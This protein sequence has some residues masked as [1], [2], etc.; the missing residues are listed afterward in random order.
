MSSMRTG[1]RSVP[2]ER[3]SGPCVLVGTTWGQ[4]GTGAALCEGATGACATVAG[5]G[6]GGGPLRDMPSA[7]EAADV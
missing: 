1:C 5:G 4:Q 2:G 7:P 3:T 6:E